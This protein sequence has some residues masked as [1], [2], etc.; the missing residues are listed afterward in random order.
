MRHRTYRNNHEETGAKVVFRRVL[1]TGT[2]D[3]KHINSLKHMFIFN[4]ILINL[5]TELCLLSAIGCLRILSITLQYNYQSSFR[6]LVAFSCR[7]FL[8]M[9]TVVF[10][11]INHILP[12]AIDN[13]PQ[14]GVNKTINANTLFLTPR[15]RDICSLHFGL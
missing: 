14:N 5:I 8:L 13:F 15:L 6:Y 11:Y 12:S 3:N 1:K 7:L 2:E 9:W 10:T 4:N